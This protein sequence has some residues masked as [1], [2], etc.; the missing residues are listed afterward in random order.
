MSS[1]SC[2]S[3]NDKGLCA[4]LLTFTRS[5]TMLLSIDVHVLSEFVGAVSLVLPNT[6]HLVFICLYFRNLFLF[7]LQDVIELV[8]SA[9]LVLL[10]KFDS[11]LLKVLIA[12]KMSSK[13]VVTILN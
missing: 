2:L 4:D 1:Q 3:A 5:L 11:Q 9:I 8:L 13:S 7:H 6:C 10:F 12:W